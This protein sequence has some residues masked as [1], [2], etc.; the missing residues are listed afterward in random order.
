MPGAITTA[1]PWLVSQFYDA[2]HQG[3]EGFG[4][5]VVSWTSAWPPNSIR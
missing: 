2:F 1:V 5:Q 3:V 4:W